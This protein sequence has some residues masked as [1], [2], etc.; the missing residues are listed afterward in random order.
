MQRANRLSLIPPYLFG[1]IARAKSAAI[2]EG[3][4]LIDLGIGDPDQPTPDAILD[5]LNVFA[6]DTSTHRYDESNMGR[7]EFL[8]DIAVWFHGRFGVNLDTETEILELI[9]SKEGLAHIVWAYI[10]AGDIS[11]VPDPGYTVVKVNTLLA[12]GTP[13]E[14]PLLPENGFLPNLSAIPNDIAAKAKILYLNY[15]NNPTGAVA[16]IEFFKEAVA[17]AKRTDTLI[18]HDCAYSEVC[19]DDY[20]APSILQVDGAKDVAIEMHSLSKTFNMTGWRIGFAVGNAEAIKALNTIKSNVDSK[21]FAAVALTAGWALNNADNEDTLS[22]LKQRRDI[23]VDGLNSLGWNIP[24]PKASFYIWV[25]VPK[26]H[27]STSFAKELLEKADVLVIP[28]LGY[29]KHG[30]GFVRMSLTVGGDVG[31]EKL[32]EAIQRIKNNIVL[33]F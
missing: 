4:N 16:T 9:G 10:D 15:P 22:L 17:F 26:G 31:G 5:H 12:G 24:K 30:D 19:Y 2:K 7:Q 21:Q 33:E 6:H 28:G 23:L 32:E 20:T 11:L 13:Y 25:P 27:T 18:V 29:G 8:E 3:R 14:F 1:E